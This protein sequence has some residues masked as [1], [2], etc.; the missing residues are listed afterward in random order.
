MPGTDGTE[1]NLA[2]TSGLC[3]LFVYPWT[4]KPGVANPPHWDEIKGAHGSTP[5]ALAYSMLYGEFEA[6]HVKLFGLSLQAT[7]WQQ[8][9]AVRNNLA[10]ALLS[11]VARQFS[12]ALGLATFSTGGVD[13]LRRRTLVLRKGIIVED[14]QHIEKPENDAA[15]IL[16]WLRAS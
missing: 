2:Q 10:Y 6:Q 5:Q 1:V 8:E 12:N 14:R 15:E 13:Y 16:N 7:K 3:V 9:F 4:G 11:D